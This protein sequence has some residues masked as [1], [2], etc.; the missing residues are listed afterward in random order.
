MASGTPSAQVR[1]PVGDLLFARTSA[2]TRLLGG[3][4]IRSGKIMRRR[5]N[6]VGWA[7]VDQKIEIFFF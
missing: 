2:N 5:N 4:V 6:N 7:R 1:V 3:K